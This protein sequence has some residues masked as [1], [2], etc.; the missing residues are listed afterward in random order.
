MDDSACIAA[1]ERTLGRRLDTAQRAESIR[2][3]HAGEAPDAIADWW[4]RL[5]AA[6]VT[7]NDPGERGRD[8]ASRRPSP[9]DA[10]LR[11]RWPDDATPSRPLQRP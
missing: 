2:R 9:S 5:E 6:R 1:I 3:C 10:G 11:H 4:Y 8:L 7:L